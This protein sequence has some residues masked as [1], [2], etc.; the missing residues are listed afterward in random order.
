MIGNL[1]QLELSNNSQALPGTGIKWREQSETS[2]G[3]LKRLASHRCHQ[4]AIPTL[5]HPTTSTTP[6]KS[7]VD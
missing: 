2:T 6:S 3:F 1:Q 4:R 5:I 7:T